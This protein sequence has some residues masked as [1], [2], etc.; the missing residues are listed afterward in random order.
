MQLKMEELSI[1]QDQSKRSQVRLDGIRKE[2]QVRASAHAH[3]L[4]N[5]RARIFPTD[6]SINVCLI[7]LF[8]FFSVVCFDVHQHS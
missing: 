8:F 2:I 5:P 4:L 7:F 6:T 1:K 3:R